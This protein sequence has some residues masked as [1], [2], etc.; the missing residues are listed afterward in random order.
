ME[1]KNFYVYEW[2]RLDTNEPFYVG[3]GCGNRATIP[4]RNRHFN[5]IINK[6]GLENLAVSFLHEGLDEKTSFEYEIYYI[7][8]YQ[9]E[10]GFNLTNLTDGGTGGNVYMYRTEEEMKETRRKL[11]EAAKNCSEETR[12]KRRDSAIRNMAKAEIREKISKSLKGRPKTLEHKMKVIE[13]NKKK[14]KEMAEKISKLKKGVPLSDS[15]KKKLSEAK[16]FKVIVILPNS[17]EIKFDSLSL[18]AI[19]LGI[20]K[21]M[22]QKICQSEKAWYSKLTKNKKFYGTR[23]IRDR[24]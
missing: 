19:Y 23:I 11:S 20:S 14:S 12:K 18:A 1:N 3:K 21:S 6:L 17:S 7:S 5:N 4:Y 9:D 2:I 10:L 24:P 16:K 22:A 15:H 13:S 8:L